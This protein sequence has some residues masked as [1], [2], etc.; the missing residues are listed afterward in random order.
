MSPCR[1]PIEAVVV[2]SLKLDA[3][4]CRIPMRIS[5]RVEGGISPSP[6]IAKLYHKMLE[7]H[8]PLCLVL[9]LLACG[10]N[11]KKKGVAEDR[12]V[13]RGRDRPLPVP[14]KYRPLPTL[15]QPLHN[16][17]KSEALSQVKKVKRRDKPSAYLDLE[18]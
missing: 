13:K 2:P 9:L 17:I 15:L 5:K 14:R 4:Q 11:G 1:A 6:E 18:P 8:D 10:L 12:G 7:T 16:E 3:S